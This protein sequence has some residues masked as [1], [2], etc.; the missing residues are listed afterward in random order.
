MIKKFNPLTSKRCRHQVDKFFDDPLHSPVHK[1]KIS[2]SLLYGILEY[3]VIQTFSNHLSIAHQVN[4]L[5]IDSVKKQY[6][7]N[8]WPPEWN[9]IRVLQKIIWLL[10]DITKSP[11]IDTPFQLIKSSNGYICHPGAGR[12][13]VGCYLSPID[14]I[15]GFYVW[16]K[17]IDPDPL[18]ELGK[19]VN[20][21]DEFINIFDF[22]K[23]FFKFKTY[24]AGS[25][26]INNSNTTFDLFLKTYK[27]AKLTEPSTIISFYDNHD[28][29]RNDDRYNFK[30]S[31]RIK[32]IGSDRC[33]FNNLEFRKVNELWIKV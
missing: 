6:N 33:I 8:K 28:P 31:D 3:D 4:L 10:D 24:K 1:F 18:V 23:Y 32:F 25:R 30:L 12:L 27:E 16:N 13:L 29:L 17:D 20:T 14:Y 11:K 7:E 19:E 22:S 5:H 15:E 21:A 26:T 2:S 9:S